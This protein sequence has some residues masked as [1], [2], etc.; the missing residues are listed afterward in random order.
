[1]HE[2]TT[3]NIANKGLSGMR[4][5][6][7]RFNFSC[8]LI[9]NRPQRRSPHGAKRNNPLLAI[10][11]NVSKHIM[12]KLHL[13][14]IVLILFIQSCKTPERKETIDELL[15]FG[16]SGFLLK[17]SLNNTYPSNYTHYQD[18]IRLEFDSTRLDIRQYFEFKK[19]SFVRIARRRTMQ[20]TEYIQMTNSDTT[21]FQ[22]LINEI[23]I[24]KNY[25]SEY[26][27]PDTLIIIYDGL[28]Y[29]LHYKT[30]LEREVT[31]NYIP[32]C[33][34]DSLKL[35]HSFIQKV[36]RKDN[37]RLTNKFEYN[38]IT[39]S[40]AIR[41]YKIFPPPPLPSNVDQTVKYVIPKR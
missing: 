4:R 23:L 15:I 5:F 36:L 28:H 41:L 35:L 19:D 6:V 29:T 13:L 27:Y 16:Y 40:E 14:L 34:P 3:H 8:T 12:T 10:L 33:L 32:E 37:P 9:G 39:R 38:K 25:K 22:K 24:H 17:D 26:D 18:S 11:S 20:T 30:S 31:L 2:R 7:A 1:M 21:G